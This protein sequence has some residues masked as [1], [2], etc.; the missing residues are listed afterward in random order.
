M[1][2]KGC[3]RDIESNG[4]ENYD[5]QR[6]GSKCQKHMLKQQKKLQTTDPASLLRTATIELAFFS[7][8]VG[9]LGRDL[10]AGFK[11]QV[12]MKTKECLKR[13]QILVLQEG[14]GRAV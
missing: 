11:I 2:L 3:C 6:F 8:F 12:Q 14:S 1:D 7:K 13:L 4:L 5:Q 10:G 9:L